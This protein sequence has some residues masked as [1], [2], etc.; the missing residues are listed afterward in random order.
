M[1]SQIKL[2]RIGGIEIGL[3]YSWF[4]IAILIVFSL[5]AHFHSVRAGWSNNAIWGIAVVTAVLFFV[6]L[7]V[8]ELAH[9]L[10]AKSRGLKVRAI[11][12]FAL[13]GVSQ[14]ESE[15]PDAKS[16]FW[17]AIV[18]PITSFVIGILC[19]W[20]ARLSGWAPR[21]EALTPTIAVLL[22]LGYIN[23]ALAVFNMLPGYPLDGGRVL[24]AVLWWIMGSA[25]R[26]THWA[27]R[28]GQAVAF[29]LILYGLYRFFVGANFGG[30]WLAF[31][32]WFLMDAARSS[33]VQFGLMAGLR[34]HRVGELMERNC[35]MVPGYLSV[36]D[37]VDEY[38][39]HSSSRCFLVTQNSHV[40]GL[41]TPHE[42]RSASR[43]DW[44]QTS[45]QSVMLPL[46]QLQAVPPEM[47]AVKAVELMT[48]E[49]L[50]Q[51]SVVSD[52]KLQGIFSRGQLLRF[53]QVYSGPKSDRHG[54]AA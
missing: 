20:G 43:E 6:A 38:L 32:G 16:E 49:N 46:S 27:S 9:S 4:L 7:L 40:V 12:L 36:R 45:V 31:I 30:L 1:H 51:L 39:L 35:P 19:L 11:T 33:Y 25:E 52:G 42:T 15:A 23:I 22:W 47:P 17:I 54:R 26:A 21:T 48:R 41:I 2:G 34:G 8:H 24:R 18:G 53:V 50:D 44:A 37:F 14:I 3:H 10:L 29:L 28:V 13:G 5:A